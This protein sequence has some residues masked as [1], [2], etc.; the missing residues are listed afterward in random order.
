[1]PAW[2]LMGTGKAIIKGR[3]YRLS[4][5]GIR[6]AATRLVAEEMGV[7]KPAGAIKAVRNCLVYG[8]TFSMATMIIIILNVEYI[9]VSW[10]NDDRTI[11]SL[12]I[13]AFLICYK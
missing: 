11:L 6:F 3:S 7:G 5:S 1:M 4:T 9:G 12:C 2:S 10:L 13:F 8:L